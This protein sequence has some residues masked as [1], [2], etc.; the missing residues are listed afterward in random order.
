MTPDP[1]DPVSLAFALDALKQKQAKGSRHYLKFIDVSTLSMGLYALPAGARDT[2][3]PH[4]EDE[5][6][7][8]TEGKAVLDVEGEKFP[9]TT[10]SILF[11]KAR[12][13]HHF[14]DIE[15]DLKVLV[16]FSKKKPF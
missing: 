7:I 11:V 10:G 4:A 14:H 2:Q 5:V 9:A 8:I 6:Y 15:E 12:V 13:K 16:L 1:A 3:S